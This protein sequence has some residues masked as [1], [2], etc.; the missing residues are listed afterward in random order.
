MVSLRAQI[1]SA[2]SRSQRLRWNSCAT[3]E[4]IAAYEE[5]LGL[6]LPDEYREFVLQVADGVELGYDVSFSML[7][8]CNLKPSS[9]S[10]SARLVVFPIQQLL[11]GE[12]ENPP[13][14]PIAGTKYARGWRELS[15]HEKMENDVALHF[16]MWQGEEVILVLSGEQRGIVYFTSRFGGLSEP[17]NL[18]FLAAL[19]HVLKT[20][21]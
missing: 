2:G 16:G 15:G 3:L 21:C 5:N 14:Y 17:R 19:D 13:S 12:G 6:S 9:S 10:H 1:E 4:Q 18:T 20:V 8:L 7:S 11:R